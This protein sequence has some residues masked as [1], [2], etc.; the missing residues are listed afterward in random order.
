MLI[1][2]PLLKQPRECDMDARQGRRLDYS[3]A[4]VQRL[5]IGAIGSPPPRPQPALVGVNQPDLQIA[6]L[7][8]RLQLLAA[9]PLSCRR[10]PD[11]DDQ[12][13]RL[14]EDLQLARVLAP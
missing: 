9:V 3:V 11:L 2:S 4:G 6:A 7:T 10:R 1:A 12:G 14:V 13:Q 5:G 8:V